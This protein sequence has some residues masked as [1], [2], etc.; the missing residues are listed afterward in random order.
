MLEPPAAND[1]D[2]TAEARF[3]K[4]AF[5]PLAFLFLFLW[6]FWH[7][8]WLAGIAVLALDIAFMMVGWWQGL[9]LLSSVAQAGLALLV[10]L[11][12]RNL[13]V[14]NQLCK[15]WR[16]TSVVHADSR[17]E[18]ELR[19]FGTVDTTPKTR[20]EGYEVPAGENPRLPWATRVA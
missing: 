5:A 16:M 6:L 9:G 18:A 4:D 19:Y 11:E 20:A 14:A 8:V 12:G 1:G 3:V 17:A 15:G 7:R 13:I 10:G 2:K